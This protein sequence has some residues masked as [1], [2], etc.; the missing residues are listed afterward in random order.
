MKVEGA[1]NDEELRATSF[2]A[3]DHITHIQDNIDPNIYRRVINAFENLR[4]VFETA[5]K[6]NP[7]S[8]A[9]PVQ[10]LLLVYG[11]VDEEL[12][13]G[14]HTF[15]KFQKEYLYFMNHRYLSAC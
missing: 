8:I 3:L 1:Y 4:P 11:L 2:A 15:V 6:T 5:L 12:F 10:G 7:D 9:K 14:W 13:Q